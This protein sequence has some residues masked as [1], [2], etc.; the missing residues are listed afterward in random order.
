M[1]SG[2]RMPR[3]GAEVPVQTRRPLAARCTGRLRRQTRGTTSRE[4]GRCC[5][6]QCVLVTM[7]APLLLAQDQSTQKTATLFDR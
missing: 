3:C 5:Q 1:R 4:R 7:N 6:T 2:N